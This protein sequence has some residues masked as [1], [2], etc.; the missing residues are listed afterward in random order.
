MGVGHGVERYLTIEGEQSGEIV[1]KKSRFIASLARVGSEQEA[2]GKI[3]AAR[4]KY[5]DARH[6][7]YAFII[8]EDGSLERCGD[9]G[10]PGGTAGRPMLEVLRGAGVKNVSAVVTRYFGGTLLGTGGLARAYA[11]AVSETLERCRIVTMRY[12]LR[13]RVGADY[14]MTGKLQ[15]L[16][17]REGITVEKMV[18]HDQVDFFIL[19]PVGA[20]DSMRKAVTEM[21]AARA[22][23][24]KLGSGYYQEQGSD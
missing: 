22:R 5:Y 24:E 17:A 2:L 18:Y 7:C 3:E 20:E 9:D 1:E 10:E 13:Y 23:L 19:L 16:F 11:R 12:G 15:Y 8:G 6:H 14:S 4:K 21:T